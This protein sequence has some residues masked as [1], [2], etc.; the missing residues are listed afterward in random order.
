MTWERAE[1]SSKH[2][3]LT[4]KITTKLFHY[5]SERS[6]TNVHIASEDLLRALYKFFCLRFYVSSDQ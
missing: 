6:S 5:Q 4:G 1:K 3:N 2:L